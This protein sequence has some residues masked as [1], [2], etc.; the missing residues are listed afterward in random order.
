M[1]TLPVEYLKECLDY[2]PETGQAFWKERPRLHFSSDRIWRK[3]NTQYA[4][5]TAG[6]VNGVTGRMMI[7][8]ADVDLLLHRVVFAIHYSYWPK[9]QLDHK[10]GNHLNNRIVNL[11]EASNAQNLKN[12]KKHVT[13]KSGYTGVTARGKRWI[14]QICVDNKV[15]HLGMFDTPEDAYTAYCRAAQIHHG[16]FA[17]SNWR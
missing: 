10:D 12:R 5:K 17:A 9:D 15:M 3:S 14:S 1:K 11:R 16:E 4:G 6:Y 8:V 13:N 2:N 7:K